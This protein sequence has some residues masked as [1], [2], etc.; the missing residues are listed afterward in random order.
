MC[1][2]EMKKRINYSTGAAVCHVP[3]REIFAIAVSDT[4][5]ASVA[6]RASQCADIAVAWHGIAQLSV[7]CKRGG[8]HMRGS[9]AAA[10]L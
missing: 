10:S 4:A 7:A 8:R 5:N 6:P 9:A 1:V 2:A 3:L